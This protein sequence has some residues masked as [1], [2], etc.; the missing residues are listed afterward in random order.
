MTANFSKRHL[1]LASLAGLGALA[2][3]ILTF[4]RKKA[5]QNK[6]DALAA[7]WSLKLETPS[8][9]SFSLAQ[10]KG[11]PLLIN[12]WATWCAPCIEEMPL[13]DKFH[14]ENYAAS[15]N[16]LQL[17]GIAADKSESVVK[18][19]S[20]APVQFPIALAGFEGIEL[21]KTLGNVSGGLPYSILISKNSGI[22][23]KKEGQLTANDFKNL[24]VLLSTA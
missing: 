5:N 23:F 10:F 14:L 3:G 8:G 12:F 1:L 9:T 4:S 17:L 20:K 13:L 22:L 19:L 15:G 6:G 2:A 18:F 11:K 24:N 16:G 21:A 7:L